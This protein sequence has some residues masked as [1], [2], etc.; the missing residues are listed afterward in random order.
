M[1]RTRQPV[2]A[3][4]AASSAPACP[5]PQHIPRTPALGLAETAPGL[6]PHLSY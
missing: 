1:Q 4:L 5:A 6:D 3:N 2:R